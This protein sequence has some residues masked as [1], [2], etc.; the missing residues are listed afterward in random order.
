MKKRTFATLVAGTVGGLLF[1]LGL[2]MCL[3]PQW[4]AF[5]VGVGCTAA[6]I[7]LLLAL[8]ILARKGKS[9]AKTNWKLV[10]KIVY[11]IVSALV[12]GIGM[13]LIMEFGRMLWGIVVGVVGILMLLGLIPMCI[14]LK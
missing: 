12:L 2:C 8:L 10:G 1:S 3:L 13:C 7:V 4:Q 5:D 14:G 9:R 11:G 6:G